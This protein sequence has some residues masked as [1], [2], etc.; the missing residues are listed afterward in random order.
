M[1]SKKKKALLRDYE[2][3]YENTPKG[4]RKKVV[5]TGEKFV[6]ELSDK[7]KKI[8]GISVLISGL[9]AVLI[10]IGI[11]FIN[12]LSSYKVYVIFP[13]CAII[14]P[15][16]YAVNCSFSLLQ[17]QKEFTLVKKVDVTV[18]LKKTIII[19]ACFSGIT[20]LCRV[21]FMIIEKGLY[22]IGAEI[23]LMFVFVAL[24]LMFIFIY[25]IV[26]GIKATKI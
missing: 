18:K 16:L 15:S 8:I 2:I 26:S 17:K 20:A 12:T 9:I 23:V 4:V 11:A 25:K 21:V 10:S 5:Y 19:S 14:A 24:A 22:N 3:E 7:R 6:L 13:Q 1:Q